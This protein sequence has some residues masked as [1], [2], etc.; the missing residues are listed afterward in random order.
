LAVRSSAVYVDT[1]LSHSL[2]TRETLRLCPGITTRCLSGGG[3]LTIDYLDAILSP[4]DFRAVASTEIGRGL[5]IS[6]VARRFPGGD[7]SVE[8][9]AL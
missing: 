2:A 8:V 7:L 6:E 3:A 9:L 4:N 1:G 5:F